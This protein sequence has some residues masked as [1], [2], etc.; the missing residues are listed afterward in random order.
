MFRALGRLCVRR[1]WLILA[2]YAVLVPI[3]IILGAP[4]VRMLKVGGFE[5]FGAESW[6][7]DRT[8]VNELGGGAPDILPISTTSR[9]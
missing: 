7:V 6:Q 8:L 1:R 9:C 2:V 3:G 5:D 4:A